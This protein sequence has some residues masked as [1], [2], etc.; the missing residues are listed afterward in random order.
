MTISNDIARMIS[1]TL[2]GESSSPWDLCD[3][4]GS[5]PLDSADFGMI[6]EC[7]TPALDVLRKIE[8]RLTG[9]DNAL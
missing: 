6:V 5:Y 7:D 2:A 1:D 3:I 8:K 4:D 9:T